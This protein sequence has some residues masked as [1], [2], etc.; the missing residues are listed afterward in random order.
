LPNL[1]IYVRD[2]DMPY[3]EQAK[4]LDPNVA[5]SQVITQALKEYL[6]Q[7]EEEGFQTITLEIGNELSNSEGVIY[8]TYRKVR[9]T[10][11]L[12]TKSVSS[13]KEK[14]YYDSVYDWFLYMT[15]K[16]GWVAVRENWYKNENEFDFAV[17]PLLLDR[18]F[19]T[20]K[21]FDELKSLKDPKNELDNL[22]PISLLNHAEEID[23]F[24]EDLD[25]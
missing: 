19:W 22:V 10:G 25:I 7:K 20:A 23:D 24:I 1:T 13:N 2:D 11:R 16:E 4:K 12:I 8:G 6:K 3:F 17:N 15:P 5:L 21:S 9:Y 18:E 14:F